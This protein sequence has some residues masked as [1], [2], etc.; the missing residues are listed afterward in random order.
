MAS[1]YNSERRYQHK[2]KMKNNWSH[3]IWKAYVSICVCVCLWM[4]ERFKLILLALGNKPFDF[5]S[6]WTTNSRQKYDTLFSIHRIW[7]NIKLKKQHSLSISI[8]LSLFTRRSCFSQIWLFH[9]SSFD[10]VVLILHA[11]MEFI[12]W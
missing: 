1:I 6:K 2:I 3:S 8:S 9:Y 5:F 11:Y 7:V 4:F 10:V 12:R